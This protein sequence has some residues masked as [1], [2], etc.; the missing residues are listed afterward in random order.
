MDQTESRSKYSDKSPVIEECLYAERGA[1]EALNTVE[2]RTVARQIVALLLTDL[3]L[4]STYVTIAKFDSS[5]EKGVYTE[6]ALRVY[7]MVAHFLSG[8]A[9]PQD[10]ERTIKNNLADLKAGLQAMGENPNNLWT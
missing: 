7:E 8:A 2:N 10:Q 6:T 1:K 3:H 4:A 9:L 5:E